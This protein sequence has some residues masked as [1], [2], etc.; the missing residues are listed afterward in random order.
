[1]CGAH[2]CFNTNLNTVDGVEVDIVLSDE[3]LHLS[4]QM[5]LQL[6][7][8]PCAVQQE[9]TAVNQLLNHVVLT[10]IGRIVAC[11]EVSLTDQIC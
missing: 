4:G 1:M 2:A 8:I 11:Y 10:Y 6:F 7:C 3:F 9:G 5:L